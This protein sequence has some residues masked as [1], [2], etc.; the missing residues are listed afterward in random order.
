MNQ[1]EPNATALVLLT[2]VAAASITTSCKSLDDPDPVP[3][4]GSSS[5]A[6]VEPGSTVSTGGPTSAPPPSAP[7]N[8][9]SAP[10][11][12]DPLPGTSE[13]DPI[14]WTKMGGS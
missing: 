14:L 13:V 12:L 5:V 4:V 11:I 7:V 9:V 10:T 2:L 3:L 8:G 1:H 6:T